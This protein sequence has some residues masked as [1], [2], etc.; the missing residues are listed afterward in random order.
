M[1]TMKRGL[2]LPNRVAFLEDYD[3]SVAPTLVAG[4]DLWLNLPRPPLEASGTSGMKA[5]LNGGLN[6]SVLD[7]WWCEGYDGQNGWAIDGSPSDDRTLQDEHDAKA[8][9]DLLEN[10]V[11]PL[12]FARDANGIPVGWLA[13]VRSSLRSL[14]PMF[15]ST[16]MLNDYVE[17]IYRPGRPH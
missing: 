5:A 2:D 11:K 10:E 6:L 7:G 16:R 1:F 12:F 8:F 3:L 15:S 17:Q 14:G 13:R 4:C 9:Y